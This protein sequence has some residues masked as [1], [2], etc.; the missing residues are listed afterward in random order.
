MILPMAWVPAPLPLNLSDIEKRWTLWSSMWYL[1][2]QLKYFGIPPA[3]R[4]IWF[5]AWRQVQQKMYEAHKALV[6]WRECPS[7]CW[8]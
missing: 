2:M 5:L 8:G 6:L 1:V 4:Y 7:L 3:L